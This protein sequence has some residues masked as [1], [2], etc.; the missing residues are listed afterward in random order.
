MM[1]IRSRNTTRTAKFLALSLTFC[2]FGF[3]LTGPAVARDW[4][5][6]QQAPTI[7]AAIDS[8]VTGDVV[9]LSPGTYSDCT[10]FSE[11]VN[12]I[13]V[14]PPGSACAVAPVTRPT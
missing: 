9:V 11:N 3:G 8:S 13:A 10:D 4:L 14:L 7:Q 2:F 5:V 1:A 6:P 12:H